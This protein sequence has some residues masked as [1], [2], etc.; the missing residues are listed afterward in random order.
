[1][2]SNSELDYKIKLS[3]KNTYF[4]KKYNI[5]PENATLTRTNGQFIVGG[6]K[7]GRSLNTKEAASIAKKDVK[8]KLERY[9]KYE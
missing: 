2:E 8:R 6:G 5:A 4:A 3:I 9:L 1:V 7:N